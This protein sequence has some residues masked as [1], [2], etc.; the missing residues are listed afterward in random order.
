MT[1][2]TGLWPDDV[3]VGTPDPTGR[4]GVVAV[5]SGGQPAAMTQ[6]CPKCGSTIWH[7]FHQDAAGR[8]VDE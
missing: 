8:L 7:V 6:A 1:D 3:Q 5:M 4:M 2:G